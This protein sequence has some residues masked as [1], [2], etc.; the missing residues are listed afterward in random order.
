[1]EAVIVEIRAAEGGA[2]AKDLVREQLALYAKYTTRRGLELEL[3]EARTGIVVCR[4]TGKGAIA[5]FENEAG[6][7]RW[8]HVPKHDKR[9]RVQTST[10]TTVVLN[11]PNH[12]QLRI[13]E[14]DLEWATCRGSGAGGQKRNKTESAVQLVHKPTGTMVRIESERSQH[15][16]RATALAVLSARLWDAQ[17]THEAETRARE[18]KGQHGTG[19]RG[20]KSRTYRVQDGIVTDHRTGKKASLDR[21]LKGFLEDLF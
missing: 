10:V 5:A 3:I 21:V 6:G 9:G 16:N 15:Q 1:M 2:D 11:E 4:V 14:R 12:A 8:Q 13:E 19:M 18:R 20:D 17:R 7:H